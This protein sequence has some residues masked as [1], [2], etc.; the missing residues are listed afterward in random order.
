MEM[1]SP[2]ARPSMTKREWRTARKAEK[3]GT[4]SIKGHD[5]FF[6]FLHRFLPLPSS[7]IFLYCTVRPYLG[8]GKEAVWTGLGIS[9][10]AFPATPP[11]AEGRGRKEWQGHKWET[12]YFF[13]GAADLYIW[14]NRKSHSW[15]LTEKKETSLRLWQKWAKEWML[16]RHACRS[17]HFM[18]SLNK[19]NCNDVII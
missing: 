1:S 13:R 17:W 12:C 18:T 15:H 8:E 16:C 9:S 19:V 11:R 6:F 7:L 4:T 10:H 14:S 5:F 2:R 3:E